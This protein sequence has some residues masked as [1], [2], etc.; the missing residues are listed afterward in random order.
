MRARDA[1][2]ALLAGSVFTWTEDGEDRGRIDPSDGHTTLRPTD[3]TSSVDITVSYEGRQKSKTLTPAETFCEF[4]FPDITLATPIPVP[5][6][7]PVPVPAPAPEPA[8]PP[9]V[10][11]GVPLWRNPTVVVA[12]ISAIPIVL[13]AYWQFVLRGS[14]KDA[15]QVTVIVYVKDRSSHAPVPQATVLL[16]GVDPQSPAPVDS[17]GTAMFPLVKAKGKTVTIVADAPNYARGSLT[18]KAS[19]QPSHLFLDRKASAAPAPQAAVAKPAP[20]NVS[21]TWVVKLQGDVSLKRIRSGTLDFAPLPDGRSSVSASL[22]LDGSPMKA[23]GIATRQGNRLFIEYEAT[24][25]EEV[26]K[27]TAQFDPAGGTTLQGFVMDNQGQPVPLT[28][29]KP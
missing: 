21:G 25:A 13:G 17:N 16:E 24:R 1:N 9:P 12:L 7:A 19:D 15:D 8:A 3:K 6:P 10:G 28:L 23:T 11:P 20:V 4:V 2:G 5:T 29:S 14:D 22:E 26:W 18:L 27:G